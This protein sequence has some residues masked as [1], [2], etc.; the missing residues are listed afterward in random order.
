MSDDIE[1]AYFELHVKD[2]GGQFRP[3]ESYT[4]MADL[5]RKGEAAFIVARNIETGIIVGVLVIAIFKNAA[6]DSSV[7]I[8]PEYHQN[9]S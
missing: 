7:S 3:R 5:A 2:A 8:D 1:Q 4:K 9:Y 6:Y